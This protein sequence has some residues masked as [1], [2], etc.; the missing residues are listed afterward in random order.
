ME[1]QSLL[2][3]KYNKLKL[4]YLELKKRVES[5]QF[6]SL[7]KRKRGFIVE[8]LNRYQRK[9][10][11]LV[12]SI[13]NGLRKQVA[14]TALAGSLLVFASA[15]QDNLPDP[16][17]M[18]PPP[19]ALADRVM[20]A[21]TGAAN[22]LD[23]VSALLFATP[24]F[25]DIDNDGDYDCF[26]GGYYGVKYYQNTGS[27]TAPVFSEQTGA[28]NPMVG[29][30][31]GYFTNVSFTDIDGDGDQDAFVGHYYGDIRYFE[32]T[33]SAS[34]P[35][36]EAR[37]G[38]DNPLDGVTTS[39]NWNKVSFVD[40][41]KDGDQDAVIARST[42]PITFYQNV[43]SATAPKFE[44][45]TVASKNPFSRIVVD[46]NYFANAVF[47]DFDDDGDMDM[48]F[49]EGFYNNLTL[50]QDTGTNDLVD[51]APTL[52]DNN[53]FSELDFTGQY[54]MFPAVVDIDGDGDLDVFVGGFYGDV[55]YFSNEVRTE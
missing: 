7:N 33:G 40:I 45:Q 43:G 3:K 4:Q 13:S 21:Q 8:R 30:N 32:N 23:G 24:T 26:L 6:A 47:G 1:H 39:F 50:F 16:A 9:L 54:L 10:E 22:P 37:T 35:T 36:F 49:S 17:E 19:V 51:L 53:V 14:S 41:D 15:C 27:A 11:L 38:A 44:V 28:N 52:S 42:G 12:K 5:K 18:A 29:I 25:V 46:N 31:T 2:I 55:V 48:V 34:A 20:V